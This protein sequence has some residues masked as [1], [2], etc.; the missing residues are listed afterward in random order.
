MA[1]LSVLFFI[2]L[3]LVIVLGGLITGIILWTTSGKG[4]AEMACGRCGYGVRGLS[5]FTCPECGA[6]LREAGIARTA[7]P[8]R[9]RTGIVLTCVCGGMTLLG[10]I[11]FG[12]LTFVSTRPSSPAYQVQPAIIQPPQTSPAPTQSPATSSQ[13]LT[14]PN[15]I[16]P[17]VDPDAAEEPKTDPNTL[18]DSTR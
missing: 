13:L 10:C 11:G 3:L 5:Q 18:D 1:A 8:A 6:D 4:S 14:D 9:R 15:A 2:V 7:S 17:P 16:T 12:S